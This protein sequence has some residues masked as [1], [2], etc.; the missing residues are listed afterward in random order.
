MQSVGAVA[1][2]VVEIRSSVDV[3]EVRSHQDHGISE[4]QVEHLQLIQA[5][6]STEQEKSAR[7]HDRVKAQSWENHPKTRVQGACQ[8]CLMK[9]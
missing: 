3:E 4:V 1:C 8:H 9:C 2:L 6:A 7:K 5:R